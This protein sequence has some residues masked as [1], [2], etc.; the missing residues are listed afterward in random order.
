MAKMTRMISVIIPSHDPGQSLQ[1]LLDALCRQT[2]PC[3]QMEVLIVTAHCLDKLMKIMHPYKT[4]FRLRVL[5]QTGQGAA[6]AR[7]CGAAAAQG[8]LLLFLDQDVEPTPELLQAHLEAHQYQPNRVVIGAYQP[9]FPDWPDFLAVGIRTWW[10]DKLHAM[11]QDNHRY[12]YQDLIV[13]NFSLETKLFR[14]IG[15]FEPTFQYGE[16]YELAIRLLKEGA[17]FH[18]APAAICVYHPISDLTG[19][20]EWARQEGAFK[21][22]IDCI[23]PELDASPDLAP[24]GPVKSSR[25]EHILNVIHTFAVRLPLM[26]DFIIAQLR[27]V[28][29][30][31]E[32]MRLRRRWRFLFRVLSMYWYWRGVAEALI[33]QPG[34]PN[35]EALQEQT[36]ADDSEVELDLS[37][38]LTTAESVLDQER[39]ASVSI[40]YGQQF[41]GRIPPRPGAERLRGAHLR[42]IMA[43]ELAVPL[44]QALAAQKII[45][46]ARN[47]IVLN[48]VAENLNDVKVE[49]DKSH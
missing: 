39:P 32:R 38:G 11:R 47:Q 42:T 43:N 33:G 12:T 35:R 46:V 1:R 24:F 48:E 22:L 25:R 20:L 23:Y 34:S 5:S 15:G 7:N 40:Y 31:L 28:L 36:G 44:L 10:A 37:K 8:E 27:Q 2:Y 13:G 16:G 6:T 26:G 17:S 19:V 49:T 3:E 29:P 14:Q 18:F 41:L 9:V 21:V 30:L 4:F 45:G